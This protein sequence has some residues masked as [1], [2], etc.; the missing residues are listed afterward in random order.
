MNLPGGKPNTARAIV[1]LASVIQ[2][3]P[4][5]APAFRDALYRAYWHEGADLSV[6]AELQRVADF[7]AVPRSV[8]LDHPEASDTVENWELDWALERLGG[9]PRVIRGDGQIL[10]GLRAMDEAAAFFRA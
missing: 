4:A 5:T 3:H 1:A 8:D 2:Q 6:M 10:W 7:A 9:V